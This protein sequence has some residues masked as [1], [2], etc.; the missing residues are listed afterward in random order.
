MRQV[1]LKVYPITELTEKALDKAINGLREDVCFDSDLDFV[2]EDWV[3][4]LTLFGFEDPKI[5]YSISY[6]QGDGA[7]FTAESWKYKKGLS[8]SLKKDYPSHTFLH[9]AAKQAVFMFQK[10]TFRASYTVIRTS[11]Y[12]SHENTVD[13]EV[14]PYSDV[15]P[16]AK[17]LMEAKH[18]VKALC[19]RIYSELKKELEY[20]N[21][22]EYL[23]ELAQANEYE[24]FEDGTRY[25]LHNVEDCK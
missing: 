24:F 12:Y 13:T 11:S 19:K 10:S 21:S 7:S 25:T 3:N 17:S 2:L 23:K 15:V 6:S 20:Q 22:A 14:S 1:S 16:S 9:E 18:I 8:E 5:A 4:I